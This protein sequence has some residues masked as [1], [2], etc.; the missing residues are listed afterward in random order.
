[1]TVNV[2]TPAA[3]SVFIKVSPITSIATGAA[4]TL[5]AIV[6]NGGPSPLYQWYK[7]G[8]IIPGATNSVYT[9]NSFANHDSMSVR[10]VSSGGCG[11]VLTDNSVIITVYGVGVTQVA[12][13]VG[14]LRLIPNPNKG[15]FTVKGSLGATVDQEVSI[16]ITDML[17]QVI[18]RNNLT[19]KSGA[20]NEPIQLSST[21]ANGMYM[22]NLRSANEHKVFHFVIEQ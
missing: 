20:I 13:L 11:G 1:M 2:D 22:L 3:P 7:N 6:T 10:V 4:D 17:G 19:A 8:N 15:I 5:T 12:S 14:D 9:S 21:L 18:Y 16:E